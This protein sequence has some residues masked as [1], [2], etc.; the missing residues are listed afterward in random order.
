MDTMKENEFLIIACKSYDDKLERLSKQIV[1]KK[2]PQMLLSKCEFGKDNYNL[3]IVNP[4]VY[5]EEED[6]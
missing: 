6:E 1:I 3:N 2:I 4:P 5:E